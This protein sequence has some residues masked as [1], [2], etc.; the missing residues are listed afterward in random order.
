M[1][2]EGRYRAELEDF[3]L[4]ISPFYSLMQPEP[5]YADRILLPP[6]LIV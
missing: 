1:E 2:K 4:R 6:G 5:Y 3:S